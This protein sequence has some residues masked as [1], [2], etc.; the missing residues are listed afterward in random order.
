LWGAYRVPL[1][2]YAPG[3]DFPR[4]WSQKVAQHT[5]V[6]CTLLD[7]AGVKENK[8]TMF[9]NSLLD[10]ND[11]GQVFLRSGE[12]HLYATSQVFSAAGPDGKTWAVN[13]QGQA[14]VDRTLLEQLKR[15]I[16]AGQQTFANGLNDGR[17]ALLP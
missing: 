7:M 8:G 13:P 9:C 3:F 16:L 5:D 17:M 4:E 2:L 15:K 6:G 1:F 11:S 12:T 14:I 10:F